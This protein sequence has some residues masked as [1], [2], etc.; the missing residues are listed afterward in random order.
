[1]LRLSVV[2]FDQKV[3]RRKLKIHYKKQSTT[4]V[5]EDCEGQEILEMEP[6]LF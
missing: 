2:G 1:M 6:K 5:E 4:Q 3:L